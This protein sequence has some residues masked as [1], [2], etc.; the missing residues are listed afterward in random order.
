MKNNHP[1]GA[2][3]HQNDAGLTHKF[4]VGEEVYDRVRPF[5][6]LVVT[7]IIGL[8]YYCKAQ[9]LHTKKELVFFERDL[10]SV[11]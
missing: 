6:K 3:T 11:A 8:L 5:Q 7:R 10:G 1:V 9:E 4:K 2:M